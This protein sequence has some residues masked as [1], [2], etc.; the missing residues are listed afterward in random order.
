ML[1][2]K[3]N[4]TNKTNI[5]NMSNMKNPTIMKKRQQRKAPDNSLANNTYI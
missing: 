2:N 3:T 4:K 1:N 5:S